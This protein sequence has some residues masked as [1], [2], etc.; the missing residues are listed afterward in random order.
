MSG[1][2]LKYSPSFAYSTLAHE[3]QHMI[4][5]NQKFVIQGGGVESAASPTW[6]DEMLAMMAQDLL[7]SKLDKDVVSGLVWQSRMPG[8]FGMYEEG[9]FSFTQNQLNRWASS[10]YYV[11]SDKYA[12]GAYLLR[13]YGGAELV[14]AI[15]ANDTVGI[16]SLDAA[17]Q[18]VADVT[19]EEAFSRYGEA[20][21]FDSRNKPDDAN[22][23]DRDVE[24]T[25]GGI[26]YNIQ[27]FN[28]WAYNEE[29]E[30]FY[31]T[32]NQVINPYSVA[33]E[34]PET[35][36]KKE[37]QGSISVTITK[38]ADGVKLYLLVK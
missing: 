17:L 3:L 10:D 21:I 22:T 11:Y 25:V 15:M 30:G 5:F 14:K 6:Y 20:I 4:N 27:A 16:P 31:S 1:D 37:V 8:F 36:R 38:P 28:P 33:I 7:V 34:V 23:Y 12:F 26:T 2:A 32:T 24:N 35:L 19:F 13:N 9:P 29:G 18:E